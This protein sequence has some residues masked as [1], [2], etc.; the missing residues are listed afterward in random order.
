MQNEGKNNNMNKRWRKKSRQN[1]EKE[2][3]SPASHR[4]N[5]VESSIIFVRIEK[6]I[7]TSIIWE[8]FDFFFF[9]IPSFLFAQA[10]NKMQL[11]GHLISLKKKNSGNEMKEKNKIIEYF[12]RAIG[13]SKFC[14]KSIMPNQ[15]DAISRSNSFWYNK[16]AVDRPRAVQHSII[17]K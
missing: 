5:A 13:G 6:E 16:R 14:R 3:H 12:R 4:A 8:Y 1:R 2:F 9:P 15:N 7:G 11:Y 10:K 17:I